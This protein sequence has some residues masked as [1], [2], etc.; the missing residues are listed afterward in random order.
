LDVFFYV[1]MMPV[2][3][4]SNLAAILSWLIITVITLI[5]ALR[6]YSRKRKS[7]G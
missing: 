4:T 3:M 2:L 1:V 7:L 6:E 5:I